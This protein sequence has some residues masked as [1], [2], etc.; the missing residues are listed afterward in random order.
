MR[1]LKVCLLLLMTLVD[2]CT[3]SSQYFLAP[4]LDDESPIDCLATFAQLHL[5]RQLFVFSLSFEH[6]RKVGINIESYWVIASG[7]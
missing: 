2:E 4:S 1:T 3:Q 5:D 7:Q 6:T